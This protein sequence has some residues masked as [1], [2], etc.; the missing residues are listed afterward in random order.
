MQENEEK[1]IIGNWYTQIAAGYWKL[2]DIKPRYATGD[3]EDHLDSTIHKK[4]ERIRDWAVLKRAFTGKMKKCKVFSEC[5]DS[6]WLTPV[7]DA[8]ACELDRALEAD[9]KHKEQF[10]TTD[11]LR[12]S[13]YNRF[14]KLTGEQAAE[15]ESKLKLLPERFTE[16]ELRRTTGLPQECMDV[17]YMD[18]NYVLNLY[19]V[20]WEI[21]EN[22]DQIYCG[23]M[24]ASLNREPRS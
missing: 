8:V 9:P 16:E 5:I 1:P 17:E 24:L 13:P 7:P 15:F 12:K 4:G 22:C 20:P 11:I 6:C 10:E 19:D 2:T 23:W 21:T 3:F 18:S 14:L